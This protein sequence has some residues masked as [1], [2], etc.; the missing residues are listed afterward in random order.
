METEYAVDGAVSKCGVR[1]E[2]MKALDVAMHYNYHL[3]MMHYIMHLEQIETLAN[4]GDVTQLGRQEMI[5]LY[6]QAQRYVDIQQQMGNF[7]P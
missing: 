4:I 2:A 7:A 5:E 1:T 3:W 6:P